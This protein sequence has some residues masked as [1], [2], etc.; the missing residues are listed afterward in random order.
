MWVEALRSGKYKQ[1]C[2]MMRDTRMNDEGYEAIPDVNPKNNNMCVMGVLADLAL[3]SSHL[4]YDLTN[5][6]KF[7]EYNDGPTT[8]TLEWAG[9]TGEE[10][11]KLIEYNDGIGEVETKTF[12]EFANYIEK[13]L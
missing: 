3:I 9:L 2:N 8:R 10:A 5:W 11:N 12:K 1:I 6:K 13:N 4:K 7:S